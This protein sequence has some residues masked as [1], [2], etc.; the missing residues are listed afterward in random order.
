VRQDKAFKTSPNGSNL[1]SHM[2]GGGR[3]LHRMR[4]QMAV[5]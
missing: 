3:D 1:I 2:K 5:A 4:T